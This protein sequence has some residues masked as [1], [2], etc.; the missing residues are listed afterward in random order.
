EKI[1]A[2]EVET[3]V[4][5]VNDDVT[6][7][8]ADG[9]EINASTI[10]TATIL[11]DEAEIIVETSAISQNARVF[12]SAKESVVSVKEYSGTTDG[13]DTFSMMIDKTVVP[14][15]DSGDIDFENNEFTIKIDDVLGDDLDVDWWIVN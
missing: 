2:E 5:A 9:E 14:Y 6:E 1:V 3:N 4:L 11:A 8:D 15:V 10:G 12:V 7:E 13:G